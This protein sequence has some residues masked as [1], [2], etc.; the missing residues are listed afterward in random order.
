MPVI[1][2]CKF[3]Q[4]TSVNRQGESRNNSLCISGRFP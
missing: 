3:L 1:A 2:K 4:I